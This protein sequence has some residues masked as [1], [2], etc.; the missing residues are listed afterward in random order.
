[1]IPLRQSVFAEVLRRA[2]D[3]RVAG[4][5]VLRS[6]AM[7]AAPRARPRSF[8]DTIDGPASLTVTP[9][10]PKTPKLRT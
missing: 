2:A 8:L 1:M 9:V 3:D 6:D 7:P 5:N 10:T 4:A